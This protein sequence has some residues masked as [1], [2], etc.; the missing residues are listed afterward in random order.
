MEPLWTKFWGKGNRESPSCGGQEDVTD[1]VAF[2]SLLSRVTCSHC[3]LPLSNPS[4][5]ITTSHIKESQATNGRLAESQQ[6]ADRW[7][8]SA[9]LMGFLLLRDA[10]HMPRGQPAESAFKVKCAARPRTDRLCLGGGFSTGACCK[11]PKSSVL[12]PH[13]CTQLLATERPGRVPVAYVALKWMSEPRHTRQP[14]QGCLSHLPCSWPGLKA[15]ISSRSFLW[16]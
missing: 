8:N 16:A 5:P 13:P 10:I 6:H 11:R 2:K 12:W 9:S 4:S 3:L 14:T 15:A 7:V 1:Q